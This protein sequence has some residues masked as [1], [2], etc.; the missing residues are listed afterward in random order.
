MYGKFSV[1]QNFL[2]AELLSAKLPDGEI[3]FYQ[4]FL[5]AKILYDGKSHDGIA[6]G[7]N[8]YGRIS[9]HVYPLLSGNTCICDAFKIHHSNVYDEPNER[10]MARRIDNLHIQR[11]EWVLGFI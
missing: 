11:V 2:T 9:E 4:R 5:T 1:R 6:Y 10:K 8:S 7:E 3:S